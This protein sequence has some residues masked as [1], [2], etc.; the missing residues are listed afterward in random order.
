MIGFIGA[1]VSRHSEAA[2][3]KLVALIWTKILPLYKPAICPVGGT[4]EHKTWFFFHYAVCVIMVVFI[5]SNS[6]IS[7]TLFWSVSLIP[8]FLTSIRK[9]K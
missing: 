1:F 6:D 5:K 8:D 9:V 3:R 4:E 2:E 7:C